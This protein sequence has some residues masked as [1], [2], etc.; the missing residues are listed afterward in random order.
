MMNAKE[1]RELTNSAI[2]TELAAIEEQIVDRAREGR[3][4]IFYPALDGDI[5]AHLQESGY[6]VEYDDWLKKYMISW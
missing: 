2:N 4:F 6:I 5:K 3:S 1:A